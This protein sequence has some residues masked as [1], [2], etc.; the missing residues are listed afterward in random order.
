MTDVNV[1]SNRW[2]SL[3]ASL[4]SLGAMAAARWS[5]LSGAGLGA[6]LCALLALGAVLLASGAL[7]RTHSISSGSRRVSAYCSSQSCCPTSG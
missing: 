2:S 5:G 7:S 4:E 3:T 1:N 6:G